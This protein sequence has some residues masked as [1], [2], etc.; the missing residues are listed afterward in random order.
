VTGR[1]VRSDTPILRRPPELEGGFAR[2]V[3]TPGFERRNELIGF[4]IGV[5]S[6]STSKSAIASRLRR[7]AP[8]LRSRS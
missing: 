4:D 5:R 8:A 7:S 2:G 3:S 1:D 6:R